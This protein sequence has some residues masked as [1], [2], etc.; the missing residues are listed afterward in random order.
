MTYRTR[1][2]ALA[3]GLAAVAAFLTLF[4]VTN[5]K[6]SVRH[7]QADVPVLVAKGDIP[8]GMLGSEVV[9]KHLLSQEQVP[10]TDV[11]QGA[12]S[13]PN[14]IA[15][16]VATQPVYT[17]EQVTARR[18]GPEA[19]SGVR[20]TLKGTLRAVQVAGDQNQVLAGTLKAGDRVDLVASLKYKVS[21]VQSGGAGGQSDVDRVAS[22]VVLR[23][24]RVL[25]VSGGPGAAGKLTSSP[26]NSQFWVMLAV[27]DS[28]SQKLF[29]VVKHGDWALELRPVLHADDSPSSVET[30]ESVLGDGL[31][32]R[33][34]IQLSGG[35]AR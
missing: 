30:I 2:I 13:D 7:Q 3:L 22:R 20:A 10:R 26:G 21:D 33:Q 1:N 16:L 31:G 18:F 23:D 28:Q 19:A 29:F 4:Y 25:R 15:N 34:F 24:L 5:Y 11:V 9:G 6:K 14:Q 8:A 35:V 32:L 12:I 17:G 27:T